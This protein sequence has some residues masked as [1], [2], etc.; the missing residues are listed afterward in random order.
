[1]KDTI[2]YLGFALVL[3]SWVIY[4]QKILAGVLAL[5]GLLLVII[6]FTAFKK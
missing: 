5:S 2:R 4:E 3:V 1:M 6:S